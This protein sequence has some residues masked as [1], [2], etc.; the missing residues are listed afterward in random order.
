MLG[1]LARLAASTTNYGGGGGRGGVPVLSSLEVAALLK[2]LSQVQLNYALAKY[3]GDVESFK[4]VQIHLMCQAGGYAA[5]NEWKTVK[6]KPR[7]MALGALAVIESVNPLLCF[8][9]NSPSMLGKKTCSCDNPRTK[10]SQVDKFDYVGVCKKHWADVWRDRY[11]LLF[12]YCE[13]MD[14]EV[15]YRVSLNNKNGRIIENSL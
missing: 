2:G 5:R 1:V 9:C 13:R 11:D 3:C 14:G 8:S 15:H 12:D 4:S 10:L 7:V 6:G